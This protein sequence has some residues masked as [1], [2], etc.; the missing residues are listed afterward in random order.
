MDGSNEDFV[1]WKMVQNTTILLFSGITLL[2]NESDEE[3]P[4]SLV[5][6]ATSLSPLPPLLHYNSLPP[7]SIIFP[8]PP[9]LYSPLPM[10]HN[11]FQTNK[12]HKSCDHYLRDQLYLHT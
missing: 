1:T 4:T 11:N 10:S 9:P 12:P 2:L 7:H 8:A 3:V 5:L 6:L